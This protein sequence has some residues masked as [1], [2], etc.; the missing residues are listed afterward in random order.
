MSFAAPALVRYL[1]DIGAI[2]PATVV[3]G[4]LMISDVSRRHSNRKVR[5]GAGPGCF[6]KQART[7]QAMSGSTLGREAL[8]YWLALRDERFAALAALMPRC[9]HY[10]PQQQIL[11]LELLSEAENLTELHG[12]LGHLPADVAGMLGRAL[13]SAHAAVGDP[14]QE[15]AS[16]RVFPRSPPWVLGIHS[17]VARQFERVSRG[18]EHLL[19]IVRQYPGFPAAL[20]ELRSGW[21]Q[22]AL[23]HGDMKWDNCLLLPGAQPG[24]PAVLR[25]VDWELADIGD[26][27]WDA[28]GLVQSFLCAW[29]L[30]MPVH[31]AASA[32]QLVDAARY[33]IEAMRPA[34]QAFWRAYLE[35][36]GIAPAEG[37]RPLVRC[38]QYAAARMIQSAYES[39]CYAQSVSAP[40]LRLLQVSLNIL[41]RPRDALRDLLGLE[42][43][44]DMTVGSAA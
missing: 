31:E 16:T 40:T 38:M 33:P 42:A 32:E 4:E 7:E 2:D 36:R 29:L 27:L 21:R 14:G 19:S 20:D 24:S 18:N 30:S 39:V 44:A 22:E 28:A 15:D 26:P 17:L 25:V 43:A 13:G 1:L 12:R 35:G 9:L 5:L 6:V 37:G 11:I 3:D 34:L 41:T 23:I 10:D 8:C